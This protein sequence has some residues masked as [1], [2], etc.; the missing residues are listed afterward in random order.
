MAGECAIDAMYYFS[1]SGR[2]T[3]LCHSRARPILLVAGVGWG[4]VV[5]L[6]LVYLVSHSSP[7]QS[8]GEL[9]K[10]VCNV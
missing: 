8:L 7:T 4:T 3:N 6:S 10:R 1:M 5:I 2:P 9:A